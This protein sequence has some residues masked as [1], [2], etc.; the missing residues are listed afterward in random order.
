MSNGVI[1][2]YEQETWLLRGAASRGRQQESGDR[3]SLTF[4]PDWDVFTQVLIIF[5]DVHQTFYDVLDKMPF[6]IS[7]IL[8][9]WEQ[10]RLNFTLCRRSL[11]H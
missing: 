9:T 2:L 8:H 6:I 1:S 10:I 4:T 5:D 3:G 7:F 11:S